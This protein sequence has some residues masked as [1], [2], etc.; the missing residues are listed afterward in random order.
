MITFPLSSPIII[1]EHF[2]F[3]QLQ[4]KTAVQKA[5]VLSPGV[6]ETSKGRDWRAYWFTRMC[7]I[8]SA[9]YWAWALACVRLMDG[10]Q[11]DHF[12]ASG[13]RVQI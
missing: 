8:A 13:S 11:T 10:H 1:L 9:I 3:R 5:A 4:G 7:D 6:L 12:V 2:H